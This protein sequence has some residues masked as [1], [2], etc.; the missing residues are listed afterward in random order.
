MVE[1]RLDK[2]M[3]I[4]EELLGKV[5]EH[6]DRYEK[7]GGAGETVR[8]FVGL[9]GETWERVT[10]F[11]EQFRENQE[12]QEAVIEDYKG[13]TEDL[14]ATIKKLENQLLILEEA[15]AKMRSRLAEEGMILTPLNG[16]RKYVV[17]R[18]NGDIEIITI[19]EGLDIFSPKQIRWDD[20]AKTTVAIFA[21][22]HV[23][24][25][26]ALKM[27]WEREK[28][29]HHRQQQKEA[30]ERGKTESQHHF[31]TVLRNSDIKWDDVVTLYEKM[32]GVRVPW[33]TLQKRQERLVEG[34]E[35]Q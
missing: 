23:I 8:S 9:A 28:E 10:W 18:V 21:G 22:P 35:N 34:G 15:S 5:K 3:E 30:F 17:E 2:Q 33:K 24:P 29:E 31:V 27:I 16:G 14:A 26:D 7:A 1:V 32:Y 13:D 4:M 11:I 6:F 12:N 19:P 25:W 20:D